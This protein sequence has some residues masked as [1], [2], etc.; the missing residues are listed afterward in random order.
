MAQ[1]YTFAQALKLAGRDLT[2]GKLVEA[3]QSGKIDGP[4]V[5][6]FGFSAQSHSG[7]T[8]AYL[9]QVNSNSTT[10]E[11]QPPRVTDRENGSIQPAPANRRSPADIALIGS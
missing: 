6:P 3:M 4:G 2:R 5:T 8:G 1:A 11:I 9:F 10:R 7:Y